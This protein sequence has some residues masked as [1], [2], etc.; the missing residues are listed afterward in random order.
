MLVESVGA[1]VLDENVEFPRNALE[2]LTVDA[3]AVVPRRAED[4]LKA[5]V[6]LRRLVEDAI[7]AA[8]FGLGVR[9]CC[10]RLMQALPAIPPTV[11]DMQSAAGLVP[12]KAA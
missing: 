7:G 11:T 2:A 3:V 12:R 5:V 1:P 9:V 8:K 4:V 6:V 10:T